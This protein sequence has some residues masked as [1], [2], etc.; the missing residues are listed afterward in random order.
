M[1]SPNTPKSPQT[2]DILKN[3]EHEL[4]DVLNP[5]KLDPTRDHYPTKLDPKL[6]SRLTNSKI[7]TI[8]TPKATIKTVKTP[9]GTIV[10]VETKSFSDKFS[11]IGIFNILLIL[12]GI[13]L[14]G[15][16]VY[17]LLNSD[18]QKHKQ[19]RILNIFSITI[20]SIFVALLLM[21]FLA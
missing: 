3:I 9:T 6:L 1:P 19:D 17:Q 2:I 14:S 11:T 21:V 15:Y 16:N 8:S 13:G 12:V 18:K 5:T 20:L 4:G 10:N 7:T